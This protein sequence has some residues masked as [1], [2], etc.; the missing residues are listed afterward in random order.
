MDEFSFFKPARFLIAVGAITFA[1]ST[2]TG[3][4]SYAADDSSAPPSC[5]EDERDPNTGKCPQAVDT[6]SGWSE[7]GKGHIEDDA[8]IAARELVRAE[9]YEEA[10]AALEALDRPEDPN[11]LNYLG[12]SHRKLGKIDK[13]LA[14]YA[15]A[16]DVD[17]DFVLAREYLGEGHVEQGDLE[18]ARLQLAEIEKRCGSSCE[19]YEDLAAVIAEAEQAT[20]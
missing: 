11:V 15:R 3:L 1:I 13:G 12:Y 18:K 14:Y 20:N 2:S 16:L 4:P 8:Y 7:S 10:I 19:A 5:S 9:H 6:E 17:P